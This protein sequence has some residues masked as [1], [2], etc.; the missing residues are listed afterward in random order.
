MY[1]EALESVEKKSIKNIKL[2]IKVKF[3]YFCLRAF[4]S[5]LENGFILHTLDTFNNIRWYNPRF[6]VSVYAGTEN[7]TC[8]LY[9]FAHA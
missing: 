3:N 6:M 4:D 5:F 1:Q 7:L 8:K 2:K 9:E